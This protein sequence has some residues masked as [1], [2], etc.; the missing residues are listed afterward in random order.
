VS[1]ELPE[2][3]ATARVEQVA[4]VG[5]GSTPLRSNKA[6]FAESGTPWITSAATGSP[7]ITRAEEFVTAAAAK[8]HRLK[9]Y[10]IGTLLVAMYGE[11]K[12]RGQVAELRLEAT[13]NQACAAVVVDETRAVRDFVKLALQASYYEMRQLAEGGNQPNLNLTKIKEFPLALPPHAE[14]RRIVAK[15]E[16]LLAR[17]N[18]ARERLEKVPL[19]LKRFRQ[20]VLAAACSGELTE[21]WRTANRIDGPVEEHWRPSS[22]GSVCEAIVDCPHSTPQWTERG[23]ICLRTTNFFVG[24]LDL[25]EVRYVSPTTYQQRVSRLV[26]RPADIVYSREGGILGIACVIPEGLRACLGQRMM[27]LRPNGELVLPNFL[28]YVLNSPE[29]LAVVRDLTGGTAAPHLN[30]GDIKQFVVPLPSLSEQKEIVARVQSLLM[31]AEAVEKETQ[32]ARVAVHLAPQVILQKAFAG[33]LVPT[34]AELAAVEGREFESAETILRRAAS[35]PIEGRL[36]AE[37]GAAPMK[38]RGRRTKA[39][40]APGM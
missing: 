34:E 24:G 23:E 33:E 15:V 18:A 12:T 40:R 37:V 4:A 20:S 1:D 9:T 25:S 28:S 7:F 2:G 8:A 35:E 19:I 6:F 3:W 21:S 38:P 16:A 13:I 27:L 5:T 30:V 39:V 10:P 32:R 29:T 11:G 17:V 14:Q 26:P 31:R 36:P 22:V